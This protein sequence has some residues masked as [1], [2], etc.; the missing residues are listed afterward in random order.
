MKINLIGNKKDGRGLASDAVVLR[1]ILEPLGYSVKDVQYNA[2]KA[3]EADLN[4][5]LEVYSARLFWYAKKN[6]IIPNMEWWKAEH[7]N[8][9]FDAIWCKTYHAYD[10]LKAKGL[11]AEY[12]AFTTEDAYRP[13]IKRQR[14][15]L[16]I[17]G[18]SRYRNTYQIVEAWERGYFTGGPE[19]TVISSELGEPPAFPGLTWIDYIDSRKIFLRM[20]NGSLFVLQPSQYEGFG[21][22]LWEARA[23]GAVLLTTDSPPMNEATAYRYV[24]SLQST[25]RLQSPVDWALVTP[26]DI[27]DKVMM[28]WNES[29]VELNC[30]R[31]LARAEWERQDRFFRKKIIKVIERVIDGSGDPNDRMEAAGTDGISS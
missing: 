19:L 18:G 2:K 28:T 8:A 30:H 23:A 31:K 29:P 13:E 20:L 14:R 6:V 3:P 15:F 21:V 5:F 1:S 9:I 17:A 4:I 22:A 24:P 25:R 10:L 16:H 12:V 11:P 26:D 7:D 27:W